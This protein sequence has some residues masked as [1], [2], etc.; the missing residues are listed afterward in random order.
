MTEYI[1]HEDREE[2]TRFCM[3]QLTRFAAPPPSEIWHYTDATGLIEILKTGHIFSTQVSCLN[4]NLEQ[5]YLGELVL[6]ELKKQSSSNADDNLKILFDKAIDG[7][8]GLD[9]SPNAN[10]VTCFSE[11][12]DD[13]GQWRGYGGGEC[14]YAIGFNP[15]DIVEILKGKNALLFP[16]HYESASHNLVV[17]EIVTWAQTYFT[18][19]VQRGV[20]D[21]PRWADAFLEAYSKAIEIL[22]CIIKHPKFSGETEHRILRP[23]MPG[24]ENSIEVRQKRTLLA[25]HLP[26]DLKF[27]TGDGSGKLPITK[28]YV[29]PGPNKQ[30]SR[31]SVSVLLHKYGYQGV[32]VE[33]SAVP[34]R[35][36]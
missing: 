33:M 6:A 1:R 31:I 18:M 20:P 26:L 36:P 5:K 25:R 32:P 23:L 16:M 12:E 34:Y 11:A 19:G 8:E 22:S 30:V 17:Q 27:S 35:L 24:D 4:D 3:H 29:G 15:T 21:I 13:L 14:G 9:L 28:I 7:L 2:Y 10:F